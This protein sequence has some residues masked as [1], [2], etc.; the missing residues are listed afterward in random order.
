VIP[1]RALSEYFYVGEAI[2][3]PGRY[4]VGLDEQQKCYGGTI[5]SVLPDHDRNVGI[6]V[7][8]TGAGHYDAHAFLYGTLPFAGFERGV[9]IGEK[10][11]EPIAIDGAAYYLEHAYPGTYVLKLWYGD[12]LE[13]RIP[14]VVPKEG[15]RFDVSAEQAQACIGFSYHYP[16]TGERG[17]IRLFPSP[18]P[19]PTP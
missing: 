1:L 5:A 8:P 6:E 18:S 2:V 14:V 3:P 7:T 4:N 17:F 11:Q 12:S 13:C 16:E 10:V 19:T 15:M 9:L